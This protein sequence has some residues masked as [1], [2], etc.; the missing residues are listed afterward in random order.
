MAA[1]V[2]AFWILATCFLLFLLVVVLI[3]GAYLLHVEQEK[4]RER[5]AERKAI[6]AAKKARAKI[7]FGG[8]SRYELDQL[9]GQYMREERKRARKRSNRPGNWTIA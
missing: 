4:E 8:F 3:I 7:E 2:N 1:L 6:E 5:I 9:V